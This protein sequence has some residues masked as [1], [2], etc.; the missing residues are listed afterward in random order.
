MSLDAWVETS[1]TATLVWEEF[2]EELVS[3][4]VF[5][6]HYDRNGI[7]LGDPQPGW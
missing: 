7:P 2:S 3:L 6:R 4:G 1:G 5:H